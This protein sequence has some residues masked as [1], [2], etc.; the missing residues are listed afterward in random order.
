MKSTQLVLCALLRRGVC[1]CEKGG[2]ILILCADNDPVCPFLSILQ[3]TLYLIAAC[4]S[5]HKVCV[6]KWL[7]LKKKFDQAC[8]YHISVFY[9]L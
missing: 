7:H 9:V 1:L 2:C 3:A 8:F 5:T 4:L 6:S